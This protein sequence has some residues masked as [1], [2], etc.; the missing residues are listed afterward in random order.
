MN[1]ADRLDEVKV[2]LLYSEVYY[3][4]PT[5]A[6]VK[7][8]LGRLN[9]FQFLK[10]TCALSSIMHNNAGVAM[11]T[12][13]QIGFVKD[14]GSVPGADQSINIL[15]TSKRVLLHEVQLGLLTRYAFQYC[16]ADT[17]TGDFGEIAL[18]L[19]LAVNELYAQ[20]QDRDELNQP[21]REAFFSIE[22]QSAVLPNERFAHVIQRYYRLFRWCDGL[23]VDAEDRLPLRS[24]F[25]RLM[26]MSPNEYLAAAFSVLSHFLAI[27]SAESLKR[28]PPFFNLTQFGSTLKRR[29]ALDAWIHR[30]SQRDYE[31]SARAIEP[32]FTVSDLAPFIEKPLVAVADEHFFCPL[33]SLLEDTLNTRLY[34]ALFAAYEYTDGVEHAK[35]F[36]RLQGH[37]L[38][39]YVGELIAMILPTGYCLHHEIR[40]VAPG[41]HRKSTDA[42]AIRVP[43][44]AAVFI[45]VTKTRFRLTE[46]LFAL[47]E[48]AVI[49][50]IESMVLRKAKQIQRSLTDLADGLYSYPETV[51]SVAPVVVTGQGI[52]GLVYLKHRIEEELRSR[53]ILQTTEALL[54]CDVE[55][56]EGLAL[57][58][59]GTVDLYALLVEK[60][61]HPDLLA[62]A[63][64]LKNY[65]HYYR[66][67]ISRK[68]TPRETVF[69]EHEEAMR[70]MVEPALRSWGLSMTFRDPATE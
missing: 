33:P 16:Q 64:S 11:E 68:Y 3:Q 57:A 10:F 19:L 69:P 52:P 22:V 2:L 30:F 62:R 15:K 46:S 12:D 66:T 54:Y 28:Q 6:F 20:V 9:Q 4:R 48:T 21:R 37:F 31:L 44:G 7:S 34:F 27:K 24:D 40:Y 70:D 61:R 32:T 47:D 18:R 17:T 23:P 53:D 25:Q 29:D 59:P 35:R 60:S 50:D 67:D 65:L 14:L 1:P 42:V 26:S 43:D 38:E 63:Q 39:S 56:L 5:S 41:G 58:A 49:K 45:E 36:S 55:E 13:W 8:L 51:T